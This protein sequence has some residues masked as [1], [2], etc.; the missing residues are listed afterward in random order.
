MSECEVCRSHDIT[1]WEQYAKR[2][3]EEH[4]LF[5]EKWMHMVFVD[6]FVHGY[7]HALEEMGWK[8]R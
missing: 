4:W 5:Q 3:A 2:L 7:K 8:S 1:G 6:G